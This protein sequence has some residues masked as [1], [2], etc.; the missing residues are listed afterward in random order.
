MNYLPNL[1]TGIPRQVSATGVWP[2]GGVRAAQELPIYGKYCGPGHGDSSG[3]SPADDAVDATCCRH[4]VCYGE[5]GYLDC[6]CDC[7]L[8][9]RMPGAIANTPSLAGQA[10]GTAAMT[11]FANSPCVHH[12]EV[13]LPVV[14]CTTIPIPYP[15]GPGKCVLF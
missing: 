11:F 15:G 6:S 5:D 2:G 10:A 12:Q 4:D 3:C 9:R 13:C 8:V 7:D 14:G 1:S